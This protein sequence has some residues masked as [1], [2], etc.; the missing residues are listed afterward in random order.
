L[1]CL[2]PVS[3]VIVCRRNDDTTEEFVTALSGATALLI[4]TPHTTPTC[5]LQLDRERAL[6]DRL[7]DEVKGGQFYILQCYTIRALSNTHVV[8]YVFARTQPRTDSTQPAFSR[9]VAG[10]PMFFAFVVD[11]VD[12]SNIKKRL[13]DTMKSRLY[14]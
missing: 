10:S 11:V 5:R 8:R 6:V 1:T 4:T 9:S 7:F 2:D 13:K 12:E 14:S 3:G